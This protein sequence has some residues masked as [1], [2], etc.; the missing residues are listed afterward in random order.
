M[1]YPLAQ[2]IEGVNEWMSRCVDEGV[3][4]FWFIVHK[5]IWPQISQINTDFFSHRVHRNHREKNILTIM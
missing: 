5:E 4:H 3:E 2:M 1:K